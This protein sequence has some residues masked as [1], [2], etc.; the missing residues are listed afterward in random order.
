MVEPTGA[1]KT[2]LPNPNNTEES[3]ESTTFMYGDRD[4]FAQDVI[5]RLDGV[6]LNILEQG[7]LNRYIQDEATCAANVVSLLRKLEAKNLDDPYQL[8]RIRKVI[9]LFDVHNFWNS[10]P[11][12]KY[13]E[14]V[15]DTDY[16]KAIEVKTVADVRQTGYDLPEGYEWCTVD[17]SDDA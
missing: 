13:Y 15:A 9:P 7:L 4:A 17:L 14:P 8:K 3:K 2:Q 12:P 10:Q 1:P 6:D 5:R 16:D 11:V